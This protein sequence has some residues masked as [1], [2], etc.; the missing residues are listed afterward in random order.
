MVRDPWATHHGG[1]ETE[2]TRKT[3]PAGDREGLRRLG[4]VIVWILLG[5]LAVI[6]LV[7][8]GHLV[9]EVAVQVLTATGTLSLA[10]Q[11]LQPAATLLVVVGTIVLVVVVLKSLVRAR[12]VAHSPGGPSALDDVIRTPILVVAALLVLVWSAA[13]P[14]S[15]PWPPLFYL[16]VILVACGVALFLTDPRLARSSAVG[17]DAGDQSESQLASSLPGV[18]ARRRRDRSHLGAFTVGTLFIIVAVLGLLGSIGIAN[19]DVR[20]FPALVLTILAGGLLFGTWIGRARWLTIL[21]VLTLPF[22]ALANIID[23]PIAGGVGSITYAPRSA[24][25]LRSSY[26][27]GA[28][29]MTLDLSALTTTAPNA[30]IVVTLAAGDLSVEIP[31][32]GIHVVI[33]SSV[34]AGQIETIGRDVHHP[35]AYRSGFDLSA[36]STYGSEYPGLIHLIVHAG[37]GAVRVYVQPTVVVQHQPD[38]A[39]NGPASSPGKGQS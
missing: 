37:V 15:G 30:T 13:Y 38:R 7:A 10:S 19:I 3:E 11:I 1:M 9:Q 25:E 31:R 36:S 14:S 8:L 17:A 27:F 22:V 16:G 23:V 26:T 39:G 24:A 2:G 21:C 35:Y 18:R 32:Q 6:S 20:I 5:L 28:G 33:E 29:S 12:S 34:R 4:W